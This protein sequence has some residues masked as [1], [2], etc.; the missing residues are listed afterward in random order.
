MTYNVLDR[1][2]SRGTRRAMAKHPLAL[3]NECRASCAQVYFIFFHLNQVYIT[4]LDVFFF[5]LQK[6]TCSPPLPLFQHQR[7]LEQYLSLALVESGWTLMSIFFFR[8]L[9]F[10]F[11][12]GSALFRSRLLVLWID[13]QS[14]ARDSDSILR[15]V[16]KTL[17]T[18]RARAEVSLTSEG[19]TCY[20]YSYML[21]HSQ[22]Q[23]RLISPSLARE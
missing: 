13:S 17:K 5:S 1:K 2:L 21:M 9:L 19:K 11:F 20:I 22:H 14:P 16:V 8:L 15:S 10:S 12:R 23:L 4:F 18:R 6:C 3:A 7:K